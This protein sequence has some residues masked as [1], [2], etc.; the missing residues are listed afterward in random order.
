MMP[1]FCTSCS[2]PRRLARWFPVVRVPAMPAYQD[3]SH[4]LLCFGVWCC[5]EHKVTTT[6][7]DVM[8][9][10]HHVAVR[11]SVARAGKPLPDLSRAYL[12]F[13]PCDQRRL[14]A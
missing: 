4:L 10:E 2:N 3:A 13:Q 5:N 6:L 11:L 1:K 9:P 14:A 12:E 8:P 7:S